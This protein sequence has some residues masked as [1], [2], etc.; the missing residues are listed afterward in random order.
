MVMVDDIYEYLVYD[1]FEFTT[2]AQVTPALQDR[3]V[4]VN[5]VS[6]SYS[7][8]GWRI[9]Y[10]AGPA[11]LIAA[12]CD[13][14]SHSTSNA[15]SISQAAATAAL[16][17][18]HSF[19][20]AW[21]ASFAHRRN[22]VCAALNA[23]DGISCSL[24]HGA[25]YLFPDCSGLFGRVTPNGKRLNNSVDV[26]AYLL[27]D[28]LVAAVPGSAFGSEGYFRISYATAEHLLDEACARI[29]RAVEALIAL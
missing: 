8:T 22:K 4:T 17:G 15:C 24:P 20:D 16:N 1:R 13:I 10:A 5:G 11:W 6:K 18:D 2:L 28:A 21:K 7:M 26:C 14:Q 12:M 25:F 27:E 29:A 3:I 9:G 23:I 19:L